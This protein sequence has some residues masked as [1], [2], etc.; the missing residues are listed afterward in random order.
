MTFYQTRRVSSMWIGI[1][2]AL[3]CKNPIYFYPAAEGPDQGILAA[4]MENGRTFS[5]PYHSPS[6]IDEFTQ[7]RHVICT[8]V[9]HMGYE[10]L[11]ASEP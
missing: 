9:A 6:E 11:W 4:A 10:I 8:T 5:H 3:K 2:Q 7:G 1:E